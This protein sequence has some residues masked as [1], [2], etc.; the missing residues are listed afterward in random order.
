MVKVLLYFPA[1][2]VAY[3]AELGSL[4]QPG[5]G[6]SR[7]MPESA[8]LALLGIALLLAAHHVRRQ[9][10]VSPQP[11]TTP[12]GRRALAVSRFSATEAAGK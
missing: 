2:L 11:L 9:R 1:I 7:Q 5:P 4:V 6:L 10:R 12:P 8:V 3:W